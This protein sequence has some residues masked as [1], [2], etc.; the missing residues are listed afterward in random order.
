ME[1][2]GAPE[3]LVSDGAGIFKATQAERIYRSLGISKETIEKRKPW[4]NYVETTFKIQK[5]M[6]DYYFARAGSWEELVAAR[7]RWVE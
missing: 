1:R 6:A 3:V 2:Y 5:L 7:D 4:Q